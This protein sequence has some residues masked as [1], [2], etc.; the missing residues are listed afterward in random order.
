MTLT[1]DRQTMYCCYHESTYQVTEFQYTQSDDATSAEWKKTRDILRYDNDEKE[2]L[3]QLKIDQNDRMLLGTAGKG[4]VIW[5]LAKDTP[6]FH[7]AMYLALPHGVRNITTKMMQSNSF[8][9][10]SKMNYAVAGVRKNLYVWCLVTKQLMKVLDAHFGRIIQ[11]EPLTIG[12]WNSV[13]TSS[14]DRSVKVW[15]INNIFEQVHVIDRHELQIDNLSLSQEHDLC[16]TVTRGC[17]GVW[18]IKT[19]RLLS[20]L[21]DSPLGAIVTHA[22]ITANAKYI[23]SSETG[24]ILIWNRVTEQV[25]FRDDQ[26]GIQQITFLDGGDKVLTVSSPNINTGNSDINKF[27][28]IGTLR[29]VPSGIVKFTFEFQ[30]RMVPGIPFRS[31]VITADGAHIITISL[32]KVNKD[33]I[34]VF[35]ASNGN[36]VHKITLKGCNIKEV[37]TVVPLPHKANQVAVIS[38]EKGSVIDIKS[39]KHIRS[40]PKWGGSITRDGKSGLYAPSR[41]GLELLELRKGTTV[42]TFIPKVAEG[43]FTVICMFTEMDEYVLYYHSGRK[44][45]RVF[46]TSDTEMIANYRLQTELTAIKSTFDGKNIVLGTVDGCISVLAIADTNKPEMIEFLSSLPSRDE[47]WKKRLKRAKAARRFRAAIR[48]ARISTR[49]SKNNV[50]KNIVEEN[51][52]EVE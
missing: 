45:L 12:N 11:L 28:G 6:I 52:N 19:G 10:S 3:L 47:E 50:G 17:V 36:P 24:K 46:R 37:L 16:V 5:D 1:K 9:I 23:I 7:E 8:M 33:C 42:K 22:E 51:G 25:L 34:S 35:N 39:K 18:E 2:M 38:S 48:I 43:V 27:T 26:P 29:C 20:T 31:A 49:F 21:A 30:F 41:G 14:I 13:I 40:I 4:F 32:D 44:T 15:N